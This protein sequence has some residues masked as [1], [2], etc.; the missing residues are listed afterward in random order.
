MI[1]PAAPIGKKCARKIKKKENEG[2]E[3]TVNWV[4]WNVEVSNI[5]E[6]MNKEASVDY[7]HTLGGREEVVKLIRSGKEREGSM[8]AERK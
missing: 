5:V 7:Y 8:M 6:T 3:R 1:L 4:N 2:C